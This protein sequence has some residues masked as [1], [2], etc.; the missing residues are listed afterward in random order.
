MKNASGVITSYSIH[1]T[2]LYEFTYVSKKVEEFYFGE[3]RLQTEH[4]VLE[5]DGDGQVYASL[6]LDNG[7]GF[8]FRTTFLVFGLSLIR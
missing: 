1:Y 6:G 4:F 2:K 8:F 5:D 3:G 7:E